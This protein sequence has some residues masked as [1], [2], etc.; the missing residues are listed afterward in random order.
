[1][2]IKHGNFD[3]LAH[4]Y[5]KYR[6]DYSPDVLQSLLRMHNGSDLSAADIGAGT[7]IWT[8]MLSNSSK[9]KIKTNIM[10]ALNLSGRAIP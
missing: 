8:R 9:I 2:S 7:G 6:P 3:N 4:N 5:S 1:M 10:L